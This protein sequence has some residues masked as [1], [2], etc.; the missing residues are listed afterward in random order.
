M[1]RSTKTTNWTKSDVAPDACSPPHND[2]RHQSR[3][4]T[5]NTVRI[6]AAAPY[7]PGPKRN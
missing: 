6:T 7:H 1:T 2:H 5:T 4:I 3:Q